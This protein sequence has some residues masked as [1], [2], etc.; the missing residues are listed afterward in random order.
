MQ[1]VV[2]V[3]CVVVDVEEDF[4]WEVEEVWHF[5]C[6]FIMYMALLYYIVFDWDSAESYCRSFMIVVLMGRIHFGFKDQ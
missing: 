1:H 4:C 6:C 3:G 5:F 2:D